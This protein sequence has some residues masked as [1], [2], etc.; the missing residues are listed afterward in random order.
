MYYIGVDIDGTLTGCMPAD[1]TGS[2]LAEAEGVEPASLPRWTNRLGTTIGAIA[3]PDRAV[4]ELRIES[5][6]PHRGYRP[7]RD[8][9][10]ANPEEL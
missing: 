4:T 3:A 9:V 7:T 1:R 5:E 2:R 8:A 6:I 10:F